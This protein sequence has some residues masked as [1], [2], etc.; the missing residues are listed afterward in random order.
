VNEALPIAQALLLPFIVF[1]GFLVN[2]DTIPGWIAWYA[3]L[4]PLRYGM[5][6]FTWINYPEP[7]DGEYVAY[8]YGY[9]LGLST[10]LWCLFGFIVS[11]RII[12]AIMFVRRAKEGFQ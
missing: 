8:T 12:A 4:S 6:A 5:E 2:L 9:D 1:S 7:I 10:C 11:T 3:Y